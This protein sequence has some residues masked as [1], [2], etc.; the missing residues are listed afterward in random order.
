MSADATASNAMVFRRPMPTARAVAADVGPS[1]RDDHRQGEPRPQQPV[2]SPAVDAAEAPVELA[3]A[4]PL[5]E[6]VG[7]VPH[8]SHQRD[9]FGTHGCPDRD[10]EYEHHRRP[11]HR[12]RVRAALC[13]VP[14]DEPEREGLMGEREE[15][16][17]RHERAQHGQDHC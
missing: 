5:A 9:D 3:E 2:V 10:R 1:E 14:V 8:A 6:R 4:V 12:G 13:R 15:Q 16:R 17:E 7:D 11:H